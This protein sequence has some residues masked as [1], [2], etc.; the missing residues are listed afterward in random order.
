MARLTP[1]ERRDRIIDAALAV[2]RRNGLAATTV[3]DVAAEMGSSS[4]LIHHYFDSMDDVLAE[5]FERVA[6]QDLEQSQA[7]MAAAPDPLAA[8]ATFI[9][10]Y[11]PIDRDWSFQLWLDAWAEAAR[12]P[13][14]QAASRRLNLA[15][16]ELLEETIRTGVEAGRFACPD[17][18]GAAW[19]ILSVLDGLALQI[20]AHPSVIARGDVERWGA[21][22]AE[23]ELGLAAGALAAS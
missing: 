12:R 1:T 14:L 3:R 10:T 13:R 18:A 17:P 16:V 19:R 8:V 11:A 20:V 4:G 6:A 21:A 7:E 5:V 15:W 23:R 2:A 9:R 22:V